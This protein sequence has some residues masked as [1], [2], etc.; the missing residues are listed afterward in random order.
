MDDCIKICIEERGPPPTDDGM[1]IIFFSII[2]GF[3]GAIAG[4][5]FYGPIG[6]IIGFIIG[7]LIIP[8]FIFSVILLIL[9]AFLVILGI[10]SPWVP[11]WGWLLMGLIIAIILLKKEVIITR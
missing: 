8:I 4:L 5:M 3:I 9:G 11:L 2:C 1:K 6:S 10:I 7:V